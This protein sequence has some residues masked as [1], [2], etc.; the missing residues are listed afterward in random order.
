MPQ[1]FRVG[2]YLVYFWV[3]E[4]NP[5]E[6]I[7]VHVS[8]GVPKENA[9]KLWITERGRCLVAH[10]KSKIPES[11]LLRIERIIEARHKEIEEKWLERFGEVNYYC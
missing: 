10:N 5:L 1:I 11:K 9:T 7:H 2:S 4:G 8:T 3:N 6:S